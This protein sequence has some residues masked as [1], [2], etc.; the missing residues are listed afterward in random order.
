MIECGSG[1]PNCVGAIFGAITY[2]DQGIRRSALGPHL[3]FDAAQLEANR[4]GIL[5]PEQY[6]DLTWSLIGLVLIIVASMVTVRWTVTADRDRL[7]RG[8]GVVGLGMCGLLLWIVGSGFIDRV[9]DRWDGRACSIAHVSSGVELG[10]YLGGYYMT[11]GLESFY[12][13][14][15]SETAWRAVERGDSYRVFYACNAMTFASAERISPP[16]EPG[17]PNEYQRELASFLEWEVTDLT[18]NRAGMYGSS[19]LFDIWGSL[20][21]FTVLGLVVLYGGVVAFQQMARTNLR[22]FVFLIGPSVGLFAAVC[23]FHSKNAVEDLL[24]VGPC[25]VTGAMT[26]SSSAGRYVR[27]T[28]KI[29]DSELDGPRLKSVAGAGIVRE[30]EEH[31]AYYR[32]S[33]A[34]LL[35]VELVEVE[36][37]L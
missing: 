20:V 7:Q 33:N 28:V 34:R 29:G 18:A 6:P 23:F 22:L 35:A 17:P 15:A 5:A 13:P 11:V 32:C 2:S 8:V 31:R 1:A 26:L 19:Q 25:R 3:G 24:D 12:L 4:Q 10:S 21:G 30:G 14:E 37:A 27:W 36:D 9:K 16:L